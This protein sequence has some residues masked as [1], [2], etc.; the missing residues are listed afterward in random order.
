VKDSTLRPSPALPDE[1]AMSSSSK[2]TTAVAL[3]DGNSLGIIFTERCK[4]APKEN[5]LDRKRR[6][7]FRFNYQWWHSI[8]KAIDEHGGGDRVAA[9]VTAG[10][11]VLLAQY[12]WLKDK[13]D[14]I[15]RD[16]ELLEETLRDLAEDLE[17]GVTE[18][19]PEGMFLSFAAGLAI[20]RTKDE[21]EGRTY[22]IQQQLRVVKRKEHD[23]KNRWKTEAHKPVHTVKAFSSKEWVEMITRP[24]GDLVEPDK[25]DSGAASDWIPD[26]RSNMVVEKTSDAVL[27]DQEDESTGD[28]DGGF[29]SNGF[30]E[31]TPDLVNRAIGELGLDGTDLTAV[32][33]D[34]MR[35]YIEKRGESEKL[36][37]LPPKKRGM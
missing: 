3:L 34:L 35:H 37:V 10:D 23:A 22:R 4:G 27:A 14:F 8:Q 21:N 11:D 36:V 31:W 5:L 2:P 32:T 16:Q 29:E 26:T 28:G 25:W 6:R 12:D 7:S 20:K 24:S 18:E 9:W 19:L 15:G 30:D 33:S 13:E 17:R 1:K